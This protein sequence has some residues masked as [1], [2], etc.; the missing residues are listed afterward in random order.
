MRM[1]LTLLNGILKKWFKSVN[2]VMCILPQ[3]QNKGSTY[4][5]LC[6]LGPDLTA[7]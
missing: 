4:A 3:L 5:M 6:N 7:H 2:F 1:Y